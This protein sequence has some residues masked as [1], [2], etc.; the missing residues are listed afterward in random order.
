VTR[1]AQ[2]DGFVEFDEEADPAQDDSFV[3][4]V[5]QKLSSATRISCRVPWVDE[6]LASFF[7]GEPHV[8]EF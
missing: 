6:V 4:G 7:Y 1:A 3:E 8:C 2:D 5:D